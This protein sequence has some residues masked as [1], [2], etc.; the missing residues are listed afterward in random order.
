MIKFLTGPNGMTATEILRLIAQLDTR[1]N[2]NET[3]YIE[4]CS[5]S[6]VVKVYSNVP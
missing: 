6:I 5:Y 4:L 1:L 3:G 2:F